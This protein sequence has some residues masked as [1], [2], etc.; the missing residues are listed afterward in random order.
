MRQSRTW[1]LTKKD[2]GLVRPQRGSAAVRLSVRV[3]TGL[4]TSADRLAE[5]S[6]RDRA[7]DA[8]IHPKAM[9]VIL[10]TNEE[11]DVWMR[12]GRGEGVATAVAG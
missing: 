10:T 4:D 3:Y 12:A 11:R 5:Q 2:V 6:G 1:K 7:V 9:L 8:P